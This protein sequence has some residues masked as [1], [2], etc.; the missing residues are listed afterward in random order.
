MLDGRVSEASQ[1]QYKPFGKPPLQ[2]EH[3]VVH[4]AVSGSSLSIS[5]AASVGLL[6]SATGITGSTLTINNTANAGNFTTV[7]DVSTGTL[8]ASG[9]ATAASFAATGPLTGA[10]LTITGAAS[11][12]PL[13]CES[14]GC[15][16]TATSGGV[17]TEHLRLLGSLPDEELGGLE[18]A[19][20]VQQQRGPRQRPGAAAAGQP[21]RAGLPGAGRRGAP[22]RAHHDQRGVGADEEPLHAAVPDHEPADPGCLVIAGNTGNVVCNTSFTD[23]SDSRVKTEIA[24]ADVAELK[25]LFDSVEAKQYKRPDMNGDLR[26]GFAWTASQEQSGRI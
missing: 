25:Q 14:L 8:T 10:T 12:G 1:V 5:G 3:A 21:E 18:Q 22:V 11:T 4:G 20:S 6:S 23:V 19:A 2:R 7:G 16:F 15:T 26:Q 17:S 9:A 13:D 24:K